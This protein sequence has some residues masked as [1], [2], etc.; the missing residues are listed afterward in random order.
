M[1]KE[2]KYKA[3]KIKP[4]R[5]PLEQNKLTRKGPNIRNKLYSN[6]HGIITKNNHLS[7]HEVSNSE[8]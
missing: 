3:N 2:L 7:D 5:K 8:K 4:S 6:V 1:G